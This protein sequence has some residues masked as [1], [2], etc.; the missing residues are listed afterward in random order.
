MCIRDRLQIS[1]QGNCSHGKLHLFMVCIKRFDTISNTAAVAIS[2]TTVA[3]SNT[4]VA[5]SNTTV[6]MPNTTVTIPHAAVP[7]ANT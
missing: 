7:I 1:Y 6:T 2:N 5:I 3:I 4:I